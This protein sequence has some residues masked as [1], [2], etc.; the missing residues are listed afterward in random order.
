MRRTIVR[1]GRPPHRLT[2]PAHTWFWC[3]FRTN[4][5]DLL[6]PWV[7][8]LSQDNCDSHGTVD[9]SQ[10]SVIFERREGSVL[11]SG[12]GRMKALRASSSSGERTSEPAPLASAS[13][14][15]Q[16]ERALVLGL[17]TIVLD[18]A[19]VCRP[20]AASRRLSS[21]RLGASQPHVEPPVSAS[22]MDVGF[23]LAW[24][25]AGY[26]LLSQVASR[27]PASG[28]RPPRPAT[29]APPRRCFVSTRRPTFA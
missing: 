16:P 20:E 18:A 15:S 3:I 28:P 6:V 27:T 21:F 10:T 29:G 23:W 8:P 22:T 5:P 4:D 19:S 26:R 17:V 13:R 12:V 2:V 7:S 1:W 25:L 14:K 9:S 24:T 11:A